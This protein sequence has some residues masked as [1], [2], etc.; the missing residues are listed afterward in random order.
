MLIQEAAAAREKPCGEAISAEIGK[1]TRRHA[2]SS[3]VVPSIASR[4]AEE[5]D[6]NEQHHL[7]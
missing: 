1:Q 6:S 7:R 2:I 5:A 3:V 4:I